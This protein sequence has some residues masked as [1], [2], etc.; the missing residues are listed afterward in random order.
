MWSPDAQGGGGGGRGVAMPTLGE[1]MGDAFRPT[2]HWASPCL[3]GA[4][5]AQL[6]RQF[7]LR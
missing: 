4:E 5:G 3:H 2:I 1:Q 6:T 7:A